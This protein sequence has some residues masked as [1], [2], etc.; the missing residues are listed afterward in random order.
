M[1]VDIG[2]SY[3]GHEST[4]SDCTSS[5]RHHSERRRGMTATPRPSETGVSVN[6]TRGVYALFTRA[7]PVTGGLDSEIVCVTTCVTTLARKLLVTF[8][9]LILIYT[10]YLYF[11]CFVAYV[12]GGPK[13]LDHF[14]KC[15]TFSYNDIGRRSI[16]Q[17]E[18]NI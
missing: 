11:V 7:F 16:Y 1:L 14:K 17:N 12:Q 15:I 4:G 2:R 6:A 5:H 10:L 8:T 18:L 3:T 13:K 9:L